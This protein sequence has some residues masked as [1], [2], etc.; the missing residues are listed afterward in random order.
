M[1]EPRE[2]IVQAPSQGDTV[3]E[4]GNRPHVYLIQARAPP[5]HVGRMGGTRVF[6]GKQMTWGRQGPD[7]LTPSPFRWSLD[8]GTAWGPWARKDK[9]ARL[10][11]PSHVGLTGLASP[12]SW[13]ST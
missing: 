7:S 2:G 4:Q 13:E 10:Q 3:P 1:Q 11:S 5:S 12:R 6:T 9:P 8:A